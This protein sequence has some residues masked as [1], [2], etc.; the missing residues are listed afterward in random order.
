MKKVIFS[1]SQMKNKKNKM[2][3]F[4]EFSELICTPK[5]GQ[6]FGGAYHIRGLF[7][8]LKRLTYPYRD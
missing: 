8:L 6:T 7:T 2:S 1:I 5:V 3:N 4:T